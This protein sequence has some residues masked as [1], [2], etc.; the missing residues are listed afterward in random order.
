MTGVFEHFPDLILS[1]AKQ[2]F[3]PPASMEIII[4]SHALLWNIYPLQGE[5][6][7]SYSCKVKCEKQCYFMETLCLLLWYVSHNRHP[8]PPCD[9]SVG[10]WWQLQSLKDN[11]Y[12]KV[13]IKVKHT[14]LSSSS[15]QPL[16]ELQARH[17][18]CCILVCCRQPASLP[19]KSISNN[20]PWQAWLQKMVR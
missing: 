16:G 17:L 12:T 13:Y 3:T 2:W 20:Q 19:Q 11:S 18:A 8:T 4:Q 6:C 15:P 9:S 1:T 10:G 5:Y 7:C 14:Y